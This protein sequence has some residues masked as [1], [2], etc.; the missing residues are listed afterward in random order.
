MKLYSVKK[1]V[2]D[3]WDYSYKE[4]RFMPK[5]LLI[6]DLGLMNIKQIEEVA[7]KYIGDVFVDLKDIE[8]NMNYIEGFGDEQWFTE[9]LFEGKNIEVRIEVDV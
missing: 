2:H 3:G 9:E 6:E 5:Y 8:R 1:V 7:K 4:R